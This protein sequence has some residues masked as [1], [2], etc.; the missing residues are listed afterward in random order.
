VSYKIEK[1]ADEPVVICTLEKGFNLGRDT[2]PYAKELQALLD[3]QPE[4][5]YLITDAR[6]LE[7]SFGD[8]IQGLTVV[9]RGDLAVVRHPKIINL[10]TVGRSALLDLGSNALKQAQ[11]G[12]LNIPVQVYTRMED[13]WSFIQKDKE[14]RTTKPK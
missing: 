5:V 13:A 2:A 4:Q 1:M 12:S 8:L 7:V 6:Q 9:A 3:S 10:I 11:Y 14:R